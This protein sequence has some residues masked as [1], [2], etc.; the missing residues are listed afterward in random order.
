MVD[1]K[2]GVVSGK[3]LEHIKK[4]LLERKKEL[5][6]QLA[7]LYQMK[8]VMGEVQDAGDQAQSLSLETL[9]ISL[10]DNE[11]A[12]Y[13]MIGQ[14]LRM[15]EDGTY[16]MCIEC[17]QPIAERRLKSYPNATRCLIC[18]EGIEDGRREG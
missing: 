2:K 1:A 12:E 14:A 16:G 5:E 4:S 18:Q 6:D 17:G 13:N 7:D 9:K 3:N 15:I 8:G 10:Q 11:M